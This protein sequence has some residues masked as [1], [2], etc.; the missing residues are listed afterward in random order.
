MFIQLHLAWPCCL[1]KGDPPAVPLLVLVLLALNLA[2]GADFD[3]VDV[4]LTVEIYSHQLSVVHHQWLVKLAS[5][6]EIHPVCLAPSA[7]SILSSCKNTS[8]KYELFGYR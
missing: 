2:R 5:A 8:N 7:T 6:L 4:Q 3:G 1:C